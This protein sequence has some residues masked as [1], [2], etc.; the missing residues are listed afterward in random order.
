MPNTGMNNTS[1]K[2]IV[3]TS[4]LCV[5]TS[6]LI[7]LAYLNDRFFL[8][9]FRMRVINVPLIYRFLYLRMIN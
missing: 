9:D 3:N 5:Q 4:Y 1:E 2:S 8:V 7:Y 6:S